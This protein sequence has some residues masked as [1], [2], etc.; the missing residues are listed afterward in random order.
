MSFKDNLATLRAVPSTPDSFATRMQA[1]RAGSGNLPAPEQ[2]KN[3]RYDQSN[4]A[5]FKR[6][7]GESVLKTVLGGYELFGGELDPTTKKA[8][9]M[10]RADV[11]ES[12][13]WGTAGSV[14]G[15]IAQLALPAG[16]LAKATKMLGGGKKAL[17]SA[18]IALSAAHGGMQLP[19]EG[20]SRVNGALEGA[21][22]A[23]LGGTVGAGLRK[24]VKGIN[25]TDQAKKLMDSGVYMTPDKAS[26]GVLPRALAY[27]MQVTPFMAKGVKEAGE[28][29]L[30]SWNKVLLNKVAP[31]REVTEVGTAGVKQLKNQ[32]N[33]AYTAAWSKASKPS[34]AAFIDMVDEGVEAGNALGGSSGVVLKGVLSD[35][36]NLSGSNY[37]SGALKE[38]DNTF[39]KRI[40]A[41]AKRGDDAL[42]D[43]L[44]SMRTTLRTAA[45]P[46]TVE[47]LRAVDSKYGEYTAVI[48]AGSAVKSMKEGVMDTDTLMAGVK[49][50]GGKAR[51]ATGDA[52]LYDFAKLSSDTLGRKEPNPIIDVLKGVAVNTPTLLPTRIMGQTTLGKTAPQR[53]LQKGYDL[54]IA[55]A[56]RN[57][58]G[59]GAVTGGA[60]LRNSDGKDEQ[61]QR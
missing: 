28:E 60:Y 8:M 18:D 19:Q 13:G 51:A 34:N 36:K 48:N 55:E 16:G 30:Q 15:E 3:Q 45:G 4:F 59:R 23:L 11:D 25:V 12:G 44:K 22:S 1:V 47:G 27:T 53:G 57:Y 37:T 46:D 33:D 52:P 24:A 38:L 49:A 10:M 50:A 2:P 35:I 42:S 29:S 5:D 61:E 21:G 31:L 40:S 20:E 14:V 43:T 41:A 39:R 54:P 9:E 26:T 58:G 7:M 56:V 6:G 32:F 17:L